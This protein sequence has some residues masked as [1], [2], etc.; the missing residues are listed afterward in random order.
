VTVAWDTIQPAIVAFIE[1]CGVVRPEHVAWEREA[2]P[3]AYDD[4]IEL[5][6]LNEDSLGYDDVEDVLI[7]PNRYAPRITGLREF[8]LS[9]RFSS[10]STATAARKSLEK[11]RAC[12]HHPRLVQ[13]LEDVGLSFLSTE[14]LVTL[15]NVEQERWQ[16]VA[17]LDVRFGVL[18]ELF[19]PDVDAS[20]EALESVGVTVADQP[21]SIPE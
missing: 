4:V 19:E 15:D 12:L 5:R 7:A 17:V 13:T 21:L 3:I 1:S 14:P 2:H 8:T 18:S 16:S 20:A 6:I 11:L 10:R 9:V